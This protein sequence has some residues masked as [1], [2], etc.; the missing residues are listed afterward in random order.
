MQQHLWG[1]PMISQIIIFIFMFTL[2][3]RTDRKEK[4]DHLYIFSIPHNLSMYKTSLFAAFCVKCFSIPGCCY[5]VLQT[6][7]KSGGE[8]ELR[9][10]TSHKAFY[11]FHRLPFRI[12]PYKF[13]AECRMVH[14]EFQI[15][16]LLR[17]QPYYA[18][19]FVIL[20]R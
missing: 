13:E 15:S 7:S 4:A 14:R 18:K 16:G 6:A 10:V 12:D 3:Y 2:I 5:C 19:P 8:A 1:N 17:K 9:S 11:V 20:F